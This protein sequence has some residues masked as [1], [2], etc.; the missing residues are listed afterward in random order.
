MRRAD[1]GD[2]VDHLKAW[3]GGR[4]ERARELGVG[5][6]QIAID[7]GL[8]FDLS[9]EQD[10]EILRRLSELRAL[11]L[12]LYVSLSRKDFIGAVLAGSWEERLPP[13]ERE[14]GTV[15][16][17]ALAVR[18]G[19]DVL[20]I[21]DR[22]SLQAVRVAAA[23]RGGGLMAKSLLET[24]WAI[25]L[26]PARRD[27]RVVAEAVEEEHTATPVDLPD[28]LSPAF[29]E[30]LR[31]AGI[32][33]L[34]SHQRE[35]Y[36]AAAESN[37]VITSGTASGKSLA[38][39]L[40]VLDAIAADPKR[41]ALYLYPTKALA[42]DQARKLG[43]LRPPNLRQAIYDG[44][45]P[46]EERPAIRRRSNLVLTNPDMLHVGVLPNHKSWGDFLANL[47][48]VVV[49]EAH[50]YRGVFGSHV[51][52]VLRRLR[53]IARAY[54]SDPRFLLASATI[55]NPEELAERLV[56]QPFRLID[57]DGAP[58]AGRELAMWNPP[59]ID[60][61]TGARRSP[62]SEA[63]ELLADL[64]SQ[65][66]RTICFL[67]SRRGIELIHRFAGEEL[68]RRGKPELAERIAPYR[69]G[70]TPQQRREIEARLTSGELLAVVA[71]DAL[72]LGIDVGE[73][74]AAICVTFP[75]TVASLRQMWGR[76]GRRRR[77]LAVYVAGQD[78]LDQ[79]FCRHPEE[80]L[81]RPVEAAILDHE[82]E[83]IAARHL[84]AAAYEL[85]LSEADDEILGPGWRERADRLRRRRRAALGGRPADR[86]AAASSSPRKIPL[87]S[88]SA[89]SV[90]VIER[91]SGEM[92]GLVEAERAFTTVHP[93][94]VYLHLGRSYEVEQLDVEAR[95]AVVT[96]FDGDWYTRPKK[97]TEIFIER[98]REQRTTSGVEL[99]FGEVSV[100][101]QV[102]AFQRV[103]I[104]DQEPFDIVA[105][106]LPEQHF[107][108]QALWY[109]LPEGLS[110]RAAAGR[111]ARRPAR[112]RARPDRGAAADRDVR[113]LGHRRALDQRPLPDRPGDDLHLRRPPR[114]RRDHPAR[115]RGVRAP[116]RRRRAP[117]RRVPLRVRLPL[118]RAEPEVRQPQRAA[119]QGGG[120]GAD[121]D[122]GGGRDDDRISGSASRGP[123]T[124]ESRAPTLLPGGG[125]DADGQSPRARV[126]RSAT[127][128]SS[129][130]CSCWTGIQDLYGL[131]GGGA[132]RLRLL[133]DLGLPSSTGR[134]S[135]PAETTQSVRLARPRRSWSGAS[136]G[137]S[138]RTGWR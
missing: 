137:S 79:F 58:R 63:A 68:Q 98:I 18:S 25:A 21:H 77:G 126:D 28:S 114:R 34:Y 45:T 130:T 70:Y 32:Q 122:D 97:E 115:L 138:R 132:R 26:D 123:W 53:R 101:E 108:T 72:E 128:S 29:A 56:G 64:V 94:A 90:A 110:R 12:A 44:D 105:L 92:L 23:I 20:R 78:A 87:R 127:S 10:L 106:E 113:P 76:A 91:E 36:E 60:K 69:G 40:P 46:R 43:E 95:R 49:D 11:G 50:T 35:A 62:L 117:D 81:D 15:A 80:F 1:Y 14:W 116:A 84:V 129:A 104:S 125:G 13:A 96:P 93:G 38:F 118:L 54:G 5:E 61:A 19:A 135:P 124:P 30:A 48:W 27:G 83:Q 51:A 4:V 82:S 41:R 136:C 8:D 66:V 120:A 7:P 42:Q 133:R 31:G 55:A 112:H 86:R 109:V 67:K 33:R 9:T 73:L 100:T 17:T 2:V 85:P 103:S 102:I 3:F 89:D 57:D 131:L 107:V 134:S 71:T 52:N 47:G 99:Y 75:G 22:S 88:A 121:A 74:D 65:G 39:N 16:A 111:P 59:L 6:E 37:L 24:P 119:A